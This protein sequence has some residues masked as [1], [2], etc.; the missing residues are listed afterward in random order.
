MAQTH[1]KETRSASEFPS[2]PNDPTSDLKDGEENVKSTCQITPTVRAV[3]VL[4]YSAQCNEEGHLEVTGDTQASINSSYCS[5]KEV[6]D[7]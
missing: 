1:C 4:P 3:E 5:S 6:A 7:V 2:P